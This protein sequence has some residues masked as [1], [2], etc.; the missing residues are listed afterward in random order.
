MKFLE[1]LSPGECF[2]FEKNF[3]ILTKDYKTNKQQE[4]LSACVDI[5]D[6]NSRWISGGAIIDLV[7]L[8]TIDLENNIIPIKES[9]KS[10]ENNF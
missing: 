1:E 7:P 8:Y 3:F 10:D 2:E 9:K 6:G 5:K 4:K